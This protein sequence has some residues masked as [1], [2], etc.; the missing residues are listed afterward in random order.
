MIK[1]ILDFQITILIDFF[2]AIFVLQEE[3]RK[4][5]RRTKLE[6]AVSLKTWV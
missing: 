4:S 6:D 1:N 2:K 5:Q 3:F